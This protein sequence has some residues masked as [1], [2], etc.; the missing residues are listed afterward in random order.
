VCFCPITVSKLTPKVKTCLIVAIDN[1]MAML[2]VYVNN[3]TI[4]DVVLKGGL[5]INIIMEQL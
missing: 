1:R 2:Q 4:E 3:N 5:R